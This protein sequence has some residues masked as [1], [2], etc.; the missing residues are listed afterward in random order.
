MRSDPHIW[1]V[2]PR[3]AALKLDVCEMSKS[4][5]GLAQ[6][7]LAATE[8]VVG[9][10]LAPVL[11]TIAVI[12][13]LYASVLLDGTGA[14][15]IAVLAALAGALIVSVIF[16]QRMLD[17]AR[18]ATLE[19]E[20]LDRLAHRDYLTDLF[21]RRGFD[22]AVAAALGSSASTGASALMIDIDRFKQ[23]NDDFGHSFGDAALRHV[24]NVLRV[25]AAG[26]R[27]VIGRQGGDEFAMLL[28]GLEQGDAI[29]LA[30]AIRNACSV[31]PLSLDGR[32]AQ[33]TVSI[34]VASS[35]GRAE[36]L[37]PIMHLADEA[38]L[39]AK[40]H[41]RNRVETAGEPGTIAQAD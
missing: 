8:T 11:A 35:A 20:R 18:D 28:P 17:L 13:V 26:R 7:G 30:E 10:P 19:K 41:G 1:P 32:P 15:R 31:D 36:P 25:A 4:K 9:L 39:S 22:Q 34:G 12:L 14:A 40:R 27:V 16:S 21:N 23:M 6:D 33:V 24:A 5:R 37:R 38:L 29:A 2:E 3:Q